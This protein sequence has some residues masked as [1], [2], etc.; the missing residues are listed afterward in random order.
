[1]PRPEAL[2]LYASSAVSCGLGNKCHPSLVLGVTSIPVAGLRRGFLSSSLAVV[3]SEESWP[4][5]GL[6]G[7]GAPHALLCLASLL[8]R[9]ELWRRQME[10]RLR[11]L[12]DPEMPPGH[13]LMPEGQRLETLGNLKQSKRERNAPSSQ[14]GSGRR[15][16][17]GTDFCP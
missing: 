7:Q 11:N 12:P 17:W 13:T 6:T 2:W 5:P 8:E 4:L 9:K 3:A 16:F 1:M 15:K 14:S 10:E